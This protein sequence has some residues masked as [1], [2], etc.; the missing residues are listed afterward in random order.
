MPQ[1]RARSLGANLG[2]AD[3][4]CPFAQSLQFACSEKGRQEWPPLD[5]KIGSQSVLVLYAPADFFAMPFSRSR[6][7]T[8]SCAAE[9]AEPQVLH[10]QL[11][12]ALVSRPGL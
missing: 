2:S 5:L 7:S 1:V 11:V 6:L 12:T 8:R 3:E 9:N 10:L 4:F